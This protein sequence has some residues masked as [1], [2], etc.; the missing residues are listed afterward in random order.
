[1]NKQELTE[2]LRATQAAKLRSWGKLVSVLKRQFDN[3]AS[4]YFFQ[5]EHKHLKMWYMPLIMNIGP[6]GINNSELAKKAMMT[7]QAMS[8]IVKELLS[9]GYIESRPSPDDKRCSMIYLTEKGQ[10]FTLDCRSVIS[11]LEA[12]YE[13]L[14]GK[15]K[16]ESLK[17]V[18]VDIIAYN[19]EHLHLGPQCNGLVQ[20]IKEAWKERER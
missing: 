15:E 6:D 12:K 16:L 11:T 5:G 9:L 7:K 18:M 17:D 19:N 8:K 10:L 14:V 20:D 4:E 2:Q 1:M 3:W 13:A